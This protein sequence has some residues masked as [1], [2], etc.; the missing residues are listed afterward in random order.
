[1]G[2]FA[3]GWALAT[4][5]VLLTGIPSRADVIHVEADGSGD[6]PTIQIAIDAAEPGD[7]VLLGPGTYKD[8]VSRSL[9]GSLAH[10]VVFLKSGVVLESSMGPE[11]T[12]IDGE[13]VRHCIVGQFL[14]PATVV[15]GI[16]IRYGYSA[17]ESG[18]GNWGGG[19]LVI[20]AGPLFENNVFK[21]CW[22]VGGGGFLSRR[23]YYGEGPILRGNVFHDNYGDDLGG[24]LEISFVDT[25]LVEN[26]T[27]ARNHSFNRAGGL[28]VNDSQGT[29][30]NNV[31][32]ANTA[33]N[34]GGAVGCI[35]GT[36]PSV[37]GGCNIFWNNQA[38]GYPNV[39]GC[40]VLIGSDGNEVLDPD[41][42]DPEMDV[43]TL[44]SDSPCAAQNSGA[45]GLIGALPVG[46]GPVSVR[47]ESWGRVKAAYR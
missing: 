15:R 32:W 1:M 30:A 43:F 36:G 44:H 45:C 28:L 13:F 21:G 12:A 38:P 29:V 18:N 14:N 9:E 11:L 42:C 47:P 31:F 27:F 35:G 33:T 40:Y 20:D 2:R 25:F 16:T 39:L 23:D 41:F 10:S 22:A 26:N 8:H 6:Y 24:G 3:R 5:L 46:C 19:V 34:G 17:G 4:L 37:S 7:T